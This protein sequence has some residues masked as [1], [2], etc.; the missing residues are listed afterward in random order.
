MKI[1][2]QGLWHCGTVI[3]TSLAHLNHNVLAFDENSKTIS[4]LKRNIP[5]V[6][7]PGLKNLIKKMSDKKKLIFTNNFK[8]LNLAEIIWFTYDTPVNAVDQAEPNKVIDNIKKTLKKLKSGKLVIISSQLPVGTVRNLEDYSKKKLK[9]KFYFFYCPENLRL[10]NGLK[11]FINPE[12]LIIGYREEAAK[13]KIYNFFKSIS[14]NLLW[15]K[16][17]SAEMTKHAINSFLASSISF[18]NEIALISEQ[19]NADANQ[20]EEGLRSEPRIGRKA[21]LSPGNP[22]SGGTLGRDVN[23]LGQIAEKL[24]INTSLINSI[25]ASNENH[26]KWIIN[27]LEEIIKRKKIK[28]V[29][30]WGLTYTNNTD[31]LR[32]SFAIEI[33]K[34]MKAKKIN[35]SAYDSQIQSYP[36]EIKKL[37]KKNNSLLSN[38]KN[39]DILLINNKSDEFLKVSENK[40]KK[41]NKNL[42]IIDPNYFCKQFKKVFGKNYIYVGKS[43]IKNKIKKTKLKFNFKNKVVIVTGASK[44]LGY[45]V[46]KSF[47]KS[48]ANLVICSRN[49][50]E[51]KNTFIK[52][53]KFKRKNQKIM[54]RKTDISIFSEVKSLINNAL[55]KFKRIDVLVNN[56]GVYGPKGKVENVDWNEFLKT[57][58]INLLGS[59]YLCRELIPYFKKNKKGKIIQL[60]G[61]GATSPLPFISAYATSKAAVVRFIENL[62]E[63]LRGYNIDVNAVAPGPLNTRML[64]EVIKAGPKKVGKEFFRKSLMQKKNGGTPFNKVDKLILF[65]ASTHSDGISGKLIS[66]L[67]DNWDNW[68]NYKD[69]LSKSEMYTLRRITASDKGYL[70]GDK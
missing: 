58:N 13:K 25:G 29:A 7:E 64:D 34:W 66:A 63:E 28:K 1:F 6:Y 38:L 18:I 15:M 60:S 37:I 49:L 5:P 8:R 12:R 61:G 42:I 57:I 56:A 54:Y 4:K 10:G 30:I 32:R 50:N 65:L 23:Y 20:I 33:V 2:I 53:K 14:N 70:W 26:K 41:I 27:K 48:G 69:I 51:I 40:V 46:S 36:K 19:T 21:F 24:R 22:F 3:S 35:T 44:G 45:N 59:I 68:I 17:E 47:L 31:T 67:W 39:T 52:L 9:K 11:S 16:T 55:K 43:I 62:S